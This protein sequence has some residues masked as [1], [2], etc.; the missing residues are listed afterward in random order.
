MS[1]KN[2]LLLG[3]GVSVA[4]LCDYL[5]QRGYHLTVASRNKTTAEEI[6]NQHRHRSFF[7]IDINLSNPENKALDEL[8]KESAIV[9]SF[10]P[11]FCQPLVTKY[12]LKHSVSLIIT[13]HIGY[14]FKTQQEFQELD[15]KAKEKGIVIVTEAGTDPGYGSMIGKK[16]IDDVH[17]KGGEVIDLWYH[18]GVLPCNPNIN[19]FGYK[20]FWAP[21]KSL[22][23]SVK[24][25]DGSGD[26]I[27]DSQIPLITGDKVYL[28]TRIVEVP[29]IGTFES[30]PNSDSGAYLYPQVYGID[31]VKNFYH[32]TLRYPGWGATFQGLIDLG[33]SDTQLRPNLLQKTY[34]EIV[35][36]L[37][38]NNNGDLKELVAKRLGIAVSDD[39]IMRYEWLGLFDD[40]PIIPPKDSLSY[41]DVISDLL[42]QRLG[43][44]HKGDQNLDQIIMYYDLLVQYPERKER[45]ISITNPSAKQGDYSMC[46]QMTSKTAAMIA[47]RLLEGSLDILG[48]KY[49]TIPEIYQPVLQEYAE[50]GISS[51]ETVLPA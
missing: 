21:K 36:E 28:A 7:S 22:F 25:K 10:L 6:V 40:K 31:N 51:Q 20:C 46:S 29:N 37:C 39:I 3:S 12:C 43:V 15:Q 27:K 38:G 42:V 47:R 23:A 1:M 44:H 41:C 35:L 16:L 34:K 17:A 24:I 9:V 19:P 5:N 50:E 13:S 14:L 45:I 30:R 4:P 18:V 49:P 8:I 33:F 26:W 11:G 32:G 48:L 2:I